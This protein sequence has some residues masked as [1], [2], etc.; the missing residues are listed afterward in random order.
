MR[1][2]ALAVRTSLKTRERQ[3][4][5]HSGSAVKATAP[6][7]LVLHS[8]PPMERMLRNHQVLQAGSLPNAT[9]L[10]AQL[11]VG[12]KTIHRDLEFMRDRLNLPIEYDGSRRGYRYTEEVSA[13]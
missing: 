7:P 9:K 6:T 13:F 10:A 5:N 4:S 2:E 1:G 12:T 11:E 8:R 3:E